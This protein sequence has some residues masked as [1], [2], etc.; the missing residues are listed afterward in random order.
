[1]SRCAPIALLACQFTASAPHAPPLAPD[2]LYFSFTQEERAHTKRGRK[3]ASIAGFC[4]S[5]RKDR[6]TREWQGN[7]NEVLNSKGQKEERRE[8]RATCD[9]IA[10]PLTPHV[11][12]H[13]RHELPRCRVSGGR[14]RERARERGEE[15][16]VRRSRPILPET[17][18]DLFLCSQ[19]SAAVDL[20]WRRQPERAGAG[21]E[22]NCLRF[23]GYTSVQ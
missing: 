19:S 7:R 22:D 18:H 20:R 16:W 2:T 8:R 21:A 17:G 14:G 3:P 1:M 9:G 13:T 12:C 15:D 6:G 23:S 5:E 11:N 4:A 10:V